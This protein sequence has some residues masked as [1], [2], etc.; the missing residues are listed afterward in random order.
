MS[1]YRVIIYFPHDDDLELEDLFDSESE[2]HD[3]ALDAIHC[4]NVGAE[5]LHWSNPGDY[6]YD[7]SDFEDVDY[8]IIEVKG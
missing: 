2:A 8:D 4:C 6:D 7:E 3:A 1:K 5:L